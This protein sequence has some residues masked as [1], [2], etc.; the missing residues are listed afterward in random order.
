MNLYPYIAGHFMIVPSAHVSSLEELDAEVW[1]HIASLAQKGVGLLKNCLKAPG[2]NMGMNLGRAGGAGIEEHI[3]LHLLPRWIGDTNFI[4]TIGEAR[5]FG[6]DFEEIYL[7]LL[8]EA[9]GCFN[10]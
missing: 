9:N 7:R 3:H 4:T 2:V 1:R 6:Y 5:V 10:D 8:N